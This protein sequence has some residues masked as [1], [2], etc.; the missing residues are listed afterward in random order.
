[1]ILNSA[2][3]K[4]KSADLGSKNGPPKNLA[5]PSADSTYLQISIT[6]L[7]C[8]CEQY[9]AT[10]QSRVIYF[11]TDDMLSTAALD[12]LKATHDLP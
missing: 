12:I 11:H 6:Y 3:N 10:G 9:A 5:P 8:I 2:K 4:T 1:M 7:Q